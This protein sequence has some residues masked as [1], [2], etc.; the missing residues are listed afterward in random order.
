MLDLTETLC[1][2][3]PDDAR[4]LGPVVSWEAAVV[5]YLLNLVSP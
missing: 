1:K 4:F 5:E 2:L 3:R